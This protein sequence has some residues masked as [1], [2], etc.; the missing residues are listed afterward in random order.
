[1]VLSNIN[2][3]VTTLCEGADLF[4]QERCD[5]GGKLSRL[6]A[7]EVR[8]LILWSPVHLRPR[9]GGKPLPGKPGLLPM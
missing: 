3:V 8:R 4:R 9:V 1:M 6:L 5:Q 2:P 7:V